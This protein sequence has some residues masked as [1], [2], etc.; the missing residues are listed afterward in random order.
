MITFGLTLKRNPFQNLSSS[1]AMSKLWNFRATFPNTSS[2]DRRLKF[3]YFMPEKS[4]T[5]KRFSV[6]LNVSLW[7]DL[8]GE[9]SNAL[10]T[11]GTQ[12]QIPCM[13]ALLLR[14]YCTTTW[15]WN[16]GS[17][18]PTIYIIYSVHVPPEHTSC[19]PQKDS[20]LWQQTTVN[21]SE[22]KLLL[23]TWPS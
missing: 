11:Q 22:K 19:P 16:E 20:T 2:L 1:K 6:E 12:A 13:G 14:N 9:S 15:L 4:G 3:K 8:D 23:Y 18:T 7:D 10:L 5:G 21:M 17:Y